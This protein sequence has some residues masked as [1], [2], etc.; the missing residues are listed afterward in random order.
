M[1]EKEPKFRC[2]C[3]CVSIWFP[4]ENGTICVDF[5]ETFWI[6]CGCHLQ[7]AQTMSLPCQSGVCTVGSQC[8]G[9]GAEGL[10][11][12]VNVHSTYNYN[13]HDMQFKVSLVNRKSLV[14]CCKIDLSF[15]EFSSAWTSTPLSV[16]HYLFSQLNYLCTYLDLEWVGLKW[17]LELKTIYRSALDLSFRSAN[18]KS[19]FSALKVETDLSFLI[20]HTESIKIW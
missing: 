15:S 6:C 8:I 11:S 4:W 20:E 17:K 10:V 1:E 14:G 7:C 18:I 13:T 3:V 12:T 16:H 2:L 19:C 5:N 9:I